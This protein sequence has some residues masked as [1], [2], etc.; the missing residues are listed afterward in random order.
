MTSPSPNPAVRVE[1]IG[2]R[3]GD[4]AALQDV[5]FEVAPGE[6]F[7]LLGPN[8][9]GKTTLFRILATLLRPAAGRA[10]VFGRDPAREPDA[11]RAL[12]G[13]VFQAPAV[14]RQLTVR[15]NL[16]IQGR[17]YGLRGRPLQRAI[18]DLLGRLRLADRGRDRV[19]TLSG[20]LVRRVEIAKGL[21]HRPQLFLLDEPSTGLDP[22]ARAD[23][24]D[25]LR[26]LR[27][28]EGTTVLFTTHLMEEAD[29]CDRLAILSAGRLVALGAPRQLKAD[30]GGDVLVICTHD[31]P[32]A[33]RGDVE[34]LTGLAAAEVDGTLRIEAPRAH[35]L[36]PRLLEAFPDRIASVTLGRP[37][38]LDVFVHRTGHRFLAGGDQPGG[39]A[40]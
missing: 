39:E 15:E 12:I 21:L 17:L 32:A 30:I 1:G 19:G 22:G 37:T 29:R 24:W 10:L 7:G 34:R 25:Y 36:V 8:G 5:T 4:R 28:S 33:L 3:F 40:A 13:V 2:H 20:G 31:D 16:D 9:G 18:D 14:D 27:D 35:T 38:L 11:V 26:T 23:L 6:M